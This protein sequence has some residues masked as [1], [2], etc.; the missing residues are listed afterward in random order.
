[1]YCLE[2]IIVAPTATCQLALCSFVLVGNM[3]ESASVCFWEKVFVW[4]LL[5]FV[6]HFAKKELGSV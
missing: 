3:L 6:P 5:I 4:S 1:M 2:A